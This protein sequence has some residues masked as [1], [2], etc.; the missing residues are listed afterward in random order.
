MKYLD[1]LSTACASGLSLVVLGNPLGCFSVAVGAGLV[2]STTLGLG[3]NS[4]D[5]FEA[6]R[7]ESAM[8]DRWYQKSKGK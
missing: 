3:Y 2:A 7:N 5:E 4:Y 6:L 1:K 8:R